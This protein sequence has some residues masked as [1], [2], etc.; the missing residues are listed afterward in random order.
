M[1]QAPRQSRGLHPIGR[2]ANVFRMSGSTPHAARPRRAEARGNSLSIEGCN[3]SGVS[4]RIEVCDVGPGVW[5][6]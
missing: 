2:A 4:Q 3:R 5:T 1:S 6:C